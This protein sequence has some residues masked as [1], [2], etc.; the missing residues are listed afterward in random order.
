[1]KVYV[2]TT[3]WNPDPN[4]AD[5]PQWMKA[6]HIKAYD[7]DEA[8]GKILSKHGLSWADVDENET[9]GWGGRPDNYLLLIVY[10]NRQPWG[11]IDLTIAPALPTQV[12]NDVTLKESLR[13]PYPHSHTPKFAPIEEPGLS[14]EKWERRYRQDTSPKPD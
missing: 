6:G 3:R 11:D 7:L 8:A 4:Q 2:I 10:K 12:I 13:H 1:M 9:G 5:T 14:R